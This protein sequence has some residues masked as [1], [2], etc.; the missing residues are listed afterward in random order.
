MRRVVHRR[1]ALLQFSDIVL[2]SGVA[3]YLAWS[4]AGLWALLA[5][6]IITMVLTIF[7]LFLWR[8]VWRPRLTWKP[9]IMRY[10]LRFGSRNALSKLLL[11]ALNHVDDLWTGA[12]LGKTALGYYSSA[13]SFATYPRSILASSV[14]KVATGTY[15]ELAQKRKSLSQA[16]FRTNAFLVR[17]G[18][19][20]AGLLALVAP[21]FIRILLDETWL[22]MV[23]TFRL[24]LIFTLLDPIKVT[25]ANLFVAVGKP[26]K[27]ARARGVQFIVLLAG[28]F[29]LGPTFGI[30][31][32]T[33]GR[34]VFP[35]ADLRHRRCRRGGRSDAIGGHG[36]PV[37][38]GASVRRFLPAASLW[39]PLTGSGSGPGCS[40]ASCRPAPGA[41]VRLVDGRGQGHRI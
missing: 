31:G 20:I 9:D 29:S 1:L 23:N 33:L 11:Q 38:P 25:V 41:R 37:E 15:A 17:T 14:N 32:R 6:N 10:F 22:P 2:S 5:T 24:M 39:H 40:L 8:P 16:F 19:L 34:P 36:H 4:G 3:L 28:L 35:G 26:E 21:E 18:F 27:V 7:L 30:D 13:Y 12:Y